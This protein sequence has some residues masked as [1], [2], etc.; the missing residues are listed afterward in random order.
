[1]SDLRTPGVR[2]LLCIPRISCVLCSRLWQTARCVVLSRDQYMPRHPYQQ[3]KQA[4]SRINMCPWK[5]SLLISMF[6]W[7]S[8]Q[9]IGWSFQKKIEV[10]SEIQIDVLGFIVCHIA[11]SFFICKFF[12]VEKSHILKVLLLVNFTGFVGRI[13]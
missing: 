4:N 6:H 8:C 12:N 13:V 7:F 10:K 9:I 1:M 11:L 3:F 2:E 5:R